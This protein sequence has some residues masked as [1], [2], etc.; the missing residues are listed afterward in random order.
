M[1]H[2][3]EIYKKILEIASDGICVLDTDGKVL[4]YSNA[5]SGMLGYSD[6]EFKEL[7]VYDWDK[8]IQKGEFANLSKHLTDQPVMFERV[9]TRKDGTEYLAQVTATAVNFNGK[10]LIYTSVRDITE[11]RN[12]LDLLNENYDLLHS[13]AQQVPGFIYQFQYFPNGS[14]RFPYA[15][16]H[17]WDI[18]EVTADEVKSDASKVYSRIHSED[19]QIVSDSILES[20]EKL[21]PWHC[22]YRVVLPKK[23]KRWLRGSANPQKLSDDS[24]LWHGYIYDITERKKIELE[25]DAQKERQ[26][27]TLEGTRAGTWEWHVQTGEVLFNDRWAE[28]IGYSLKELE[29]ISIDTWIK[30]THPEDLES[31]KNML[32][33]CFDRELDYYEIELRMKH[34]DGHWIWIMDRGK[35]G[36]WSEDGK[37]LLMHGTHIDISH[38]KQT[39]A[40]LKASESKFRSIFE[41]SAIG[42]ARLTT[43][44]KYIEVNDKFCEILGYSKEELESMTFEDITHKDDL[45]EDHIS[46]QR[47]LDGYADSITREKRYIRKSGEII[48]VRVTASLINDSNGQYTLSC[49]ENIT[50]SKTLYLALEESEKKLKVINQDL[51]RLVDEE[52]E[53]KLRS[54]EKYKYLFNTVNE[55]LCV[56]A[57]NNDKSSTEFIELNEKMCDL[58]GYSKPELLTMKPLDLFTEETLQM[59]PE[60]AAELQQTGTVFYESELI[61]RDGKKMTC[62]IMSTL[63]RLHGETLVI[64]AI[65]D[66]TEAKKLAKDNM[67]KEQLLI[68]QSK[69]ADMGKMIASI[70]HQW[71]QPLNII[72]LSMDM[73][74]DELKKDPLLSDLI[75][76]VQGQIK[77]MA[78]TVDDFGSFFSPSKTKQVFNLRE[79]IDN[80]IR[81]LD[82]KM[83]T[84]SIAIEIIGD[85]AASAYGFRNEFMQVMINLLNNASEALEQ[86]ESNNGI[87]KISIEESGADS[88]VRVKDNAGGIPKSILPDKIFEPYVTTKSGSG[89]GIGLSI[90]KS[91][92]ENYMDGILSVHNAD[93]GAEFTISLP[94]K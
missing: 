90:S 20:F 37:P 61:R 63:A 75:D 88:L 50:E 29:P 65:R 35:V 54:E 27:Y 5:I 66:V 81:I 31:A 24:V 1:N 70:T 8:H 59:L 14:S 40:Q 58:F 21:T 57:V 4:E 80:V 71:K 69:L 60:K 23:G 33:K 77:Y 74:Q 39:E 72:S 92:I 73:I 93:N 56:Y 13:L 32:Q 15:S 28:M 2:N 12:H 26:E 55:A 38:Q 16:N 41:K 62:E 89:A 3:E 34:R 52:V 30:Y 53:K 18:Y 36:K 78:Q 83:K 49:V 46:K 45:L 84:G 25:R 7:A 11:Q 51:N 67:Q 79:A 85:N 42:M 6:S 94:S 44:G 10:R 17:I 91:I 19:A 76:T 9:H 64:T 86:K 48:W 47:V 87:I 68:H 22:D 43:L 82:P